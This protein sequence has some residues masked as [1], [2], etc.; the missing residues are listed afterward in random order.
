MI[1]SRIDKGVEAPFTIACLSHL[2]WDAKLFQRPQ[3]VMSRFAKRHRV[4]YFCQVPTK[5]F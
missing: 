1:A 4:D 5:A 3:Q 2:S